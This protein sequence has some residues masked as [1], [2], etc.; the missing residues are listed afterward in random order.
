[1]VAEPGY[2]VVA[3]TRAG[4]ATRLNSLYSVT[5]EASVFLG[6]SQRLGGGVSTV[7]RKDE[8]MD[9]SADL[10]VIGMGLGQGK[11]QECIFV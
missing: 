10:S 1:M 8:G 6:L 4:T 5:T 7:L 3:N 2:P 11:H 9:D